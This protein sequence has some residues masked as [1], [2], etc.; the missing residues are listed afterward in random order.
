MNPYKSLP[1]YYQVPQFLGVSGIPPPSLL[2][3]AAPALWTQ[4]PGHRPP[5]SATVGLG[6]HGSWPPETESL[7]L[8]FAWC[9]KQFVALIAWH[10]TQCYLGN[11]SWNGVAPVI[12]NFERWGFTWNKPSSYWG[13]RMTSWKPPNVNTLHFFTASG[14]GGKSRA[15]SK[16]LVVAHWD[17]GMDGLLLSTIGIWWF[18]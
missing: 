9:L 11:C 17:R 12:I 3:I 16:S 4:L 1:N 2:P 14:R 5:P 10:L 13:I 6:V 18:P 7:D 15:C 8:N